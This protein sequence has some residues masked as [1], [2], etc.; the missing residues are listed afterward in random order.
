MSEF[1][2]K[3]VLIT[4]GTSGMGLVTAKLFSQK[5]A[6]VFIAGR[7]E[8]QGKKAVEE[9]RE[10][11]GRI[12]FIRC[13]VTQKNEVSAMID[14]IVSVAGS[15]DIAF[16][17]SGITSKTHLPVADF[18]EEEWVNI[19]NI[20]LNGLFYCLKY[21]IMAMLKN[22]AGVITNN[23]S[24][25]GLVSMPMQ[26]AYAAS[27]SGVIAL[28]ESAAIDYAQKGIRINAIAPGPVMGGMNSLERLNANPERTEKKFSLTA[29][30]RFAEPIEIANVVAW[31]SSNK[32]TYITGA[33][34][35]VD[36]GFTAGKW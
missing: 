9:I 30:K 33:T 1:E 29:M 12:E 15:L 7:G 13:D 3:N 18:D 17:N 31:L 14:H 25:A 2:N 27:K 4:G 22:H 21:E 6:N 36:G 35:A 28:T 11:K 34:I 26:A 23:S 5:G 20:N 19:V 24:V 16:N 32:A 8:V 10:S